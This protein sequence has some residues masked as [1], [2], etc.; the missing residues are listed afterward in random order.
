MFISSLGQEVDKKDEK[1]NKHTHQRVGVNGLLETQRKDDKKVIN[2]AGRHVVLS[3][4]WD[5][6]VINGTKYVEIG[7]YSYGR[8]HFLNFDV[9]C[10]DDDD[11]DDK[12][13][14]NSS[15]TYDQNDNF[16]DYGGQQEKQLKKK[17]R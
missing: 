10:N 16:R 17:S 2:H 11:Y 7:R 1:N 4:N 5:Y 3:T 6:K 13:I 14:R 15:R 9:R 12:N 8:F